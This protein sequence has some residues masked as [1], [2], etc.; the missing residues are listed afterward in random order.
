MRQTIYECRLTADPDTVRYAET[1]ADAIAYL[2]YCGGGIYRNTLHRFDCPIR[3]KLAQ[4]LN[5]QSY[6]ERHDRWSAR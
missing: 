5:A 6:A 3:P 1:E 4:P 2:E